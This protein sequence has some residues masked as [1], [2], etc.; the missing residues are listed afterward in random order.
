MIAGVGIPRTLAV[1]EIQRLGMEIIGVLS[2]IDP[3]KYALQPTTS[4]AASYR[5]HAAMQL[6]MHR[7]VKLNEVALFGIT[8]DGA[9]LP[10]IRFE[11]VHRDLPTNFEPVTDPVSGIMFHVVLS[12]MSTVYKELPEPLNLQFDGSSL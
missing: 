4:D 1:A 8:K 11:K 9:V 7:D 6:A 5:M 10:M 3:S 2:P 12:P